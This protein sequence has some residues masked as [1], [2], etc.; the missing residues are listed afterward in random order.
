ML[1]GDSDTICYYSNR[2]GAVVQLPPGVY[3]LSNHLLDSAWPKVERGKMLLQGALSDDRFKAE[4]IFSVLGDTHKPQDELLPD[5]GV[6][7]VWERLLAPV[8]ITG[9]LYGTR[10]SA[11][12]MIRDDGHTEFR[13]RTF[14][15]SVDGWQLVGEK[16]YTLD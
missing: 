3:G 8:F 10:S 2:A 14:S 1:F 4:D 12:I 15:H 6:G 5:T 9:E 13:E 7:I 11:V 16:C